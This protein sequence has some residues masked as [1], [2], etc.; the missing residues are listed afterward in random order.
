MSAKFFAALLLGACAVA[1]AQTYP[2]KPITLIVPFAAGGP[3]DVVARQVGS[4]MAKSLGQ[5]IVVENRPSIG[6]IVG[7]EAVIRAEPDGHTLLIHNIGMA[8]LPTLSRNL[9]FNPLRDF[10]YVG[11]VVDV[12]MTLVGRKDLPPTGFKELNAYLSEKRREINLANA[13]IGTAS[14]LC[15]L[16]LMSRLGIPMTS[17]PYKGAAPA[18][19][20]LMGRQVDLLCD[21]VTTTTQPIR[22]GLVKAYAATTKARLPT[23]A[24]VP[25]LAE[26]S[27][28]GFEMS[29]WHGIYAPKNT[30]KEVIEKISGALKRALVD[31]EFT[32][33]M[34]KL[35][36]LP[37]SADRA[38]PEGLQRQ[39]QREI[40]RWTPI[41][42]QAEAYI[43]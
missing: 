2:S 19:S 30:P 20:D 23:L 25:T 28:Q 43:D 29:V 37:V 36:A 13:G 16:L 21:Q 41:I 15:S 4:A 10:A 34:A 18:M 11:E 7:S 8:T 22:G 35:G 32:D 14:H 26:Q 24:D 42:K 12:P 40:E 33:A 3:T 31:K 1:G 27:T 5:A 38:T 9:R 17:V 6:G 39:L